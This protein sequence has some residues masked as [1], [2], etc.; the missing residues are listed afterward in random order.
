MYVLHK[1]ENTCSDDDMTT[2]P[3]DTKGCI[4]GQGRLH[5][6]VISGERSG[7]H[8]PSGPF[9]SLGGAPEN[10]LVEQGVKCSSARQAPVASKVPPVVD[11]A[12]RSSTHLLAE[13]LSRF[14]L[15]L[16]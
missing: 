8:R 4:G 15:W 7:H 16:A 13:R 5:G 9:T 11:R 6:R 2:R 1:M 3:Y 10:V 14:Q 12:E